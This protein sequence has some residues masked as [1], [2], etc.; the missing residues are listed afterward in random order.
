[1]HPLSSIYNSQR[2]AGSQ[3]KS[4][5]ARRIFQTHCFNPY[6][7]SITSAPKMTAM[8]EMWGDVFALWLFTKFTVGAWKAKDSSLPAKRQHAREFDVLKC[9]TISRC[10]WQI[11]PSSHQRTLKVHGS[12]LCRKE[13]RALHFS[14]QTPICII[15]LLHQSHE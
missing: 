14:P 12:S 9:V 15:Q 13:R 10:L 6:Q 1:M 7:H 3:R 4:P 11:H 2:D 8:M 5:K